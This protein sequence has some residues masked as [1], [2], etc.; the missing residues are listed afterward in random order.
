MKYCNKC[1]SHKPLDQF[2]KDKQKKDGLMSVCRSCNYAKTRAYADSNPEKTKAYFA[3]RNKK[4]RESKPPRDKISP[5]KE[6]HP[7]KYKEILSDYYSKNREK[8][9]EQQRQYYK[10]NREKFSEYSRKQREAGG[11]DYK[12]R[13]AQCTARRRARI[14]DAVPGWFDGQA[15]DAMYELA[16]RL[17]AETG[18]RHE[19]DHIVP[20]RSSLVCGLHWHGNMQVLTKKKNATKGNRHWPDMP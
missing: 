19:V 15:C 3:E 7:E 16:A 14:L 5:W 9:R 18:V 11:Q 8:I 12:T 17:T 2:T 1:S 13:R 4:I 6:R 20:V 10:E